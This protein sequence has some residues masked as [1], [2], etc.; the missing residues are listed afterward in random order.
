MQLKA[1]SP[2]PHLAKDHGCRHQQAGAVWGKSLLSLGPC[3]EKLPCP[4]EGKILWG[5]EEVKKKKELGAERLS[6]SA[7]PCAKGNTRARSSW[8]FRSSS[9][10]ALKT[11]G[12][13]SYFLSPLFP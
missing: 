11:W 13:C 6:C 1:P 12:S 4:T 5:G 9:H 2:T 8:L 7:Q 10:E 3:Q